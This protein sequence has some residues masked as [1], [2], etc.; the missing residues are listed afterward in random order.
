MNYVE[1]TRSVHGWKEHASTMILLGKKPNSEAGTVQIN[2]INS[3][4]QNPINSVVLTDFSLGN[5]N[6]G[7]KPYF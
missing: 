3:K 4:K 5:L 2:W 6:L 1:F 7:S